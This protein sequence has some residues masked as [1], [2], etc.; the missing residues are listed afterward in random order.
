MS[1]RSNLEMLLPRTGRP[2]DDWHWATVTAISPLRV[3]LDGE[4]TAL[5][6]TPDTLVAGL[7]VGARVWCQIH[8]RRLVIV[9]QA[10]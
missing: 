6:I 2:S 9:G 8:G 10:H 7:A 3:R 1:T 5:P 4:A